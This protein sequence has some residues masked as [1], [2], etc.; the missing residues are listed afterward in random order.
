MN[1]T[2]LTRTFNALSDPTRLGLVK[3]LMA[4][5]RNV[6]TLCMALKA[7]QPTV[8]HHLGILKANNIVTCRPKGRCVYYS[9]KPKALTQAL[10]FIL[11]ARNVKA[12]ASAEK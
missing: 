10:K 7:R 11:A 1:T 5:P 2:N 3:A 4:G 6:T 8:S 9:L 12:A